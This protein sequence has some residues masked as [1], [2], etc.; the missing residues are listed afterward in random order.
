MKYRDEEYE[1]IAHP[2]IQHLNILLVSLA[3][4]NPHVHSEF[5]ISTV[6]EGEAVV[7][8]N[9]KSETTKK[10]S[11]LLLNPDQP[12]EIQAVGKDRTLILAVQLSPKFYASYSPSTQN[13]EFQELFA[14]HGEEPMSNMFF[15]SLLSLAYQYF[16]G[17][18]G[19]EFECV[20]L[21]NLILARL[22][23][24]I[25]FIRI[26]DQ[27]LAERDLRTRRLSRITTFINDHYTEKLLLSDI[28]EQEGLSMTYLSHFFRDNLNITFQQY[29]NNI[30]FEK[31]LQLMAGTNK[32]L[33]D[34]SMESG[35]SDS[36]YLNRMFMERFHCSPREYYKNM[37]DAKRD[38]SMRACIQTVFSEQE[39][40]SLLAPYIKKIESSVVHL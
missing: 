36:K 27:A 3:Y 39:C 30:R 25:P 21:M 31:A 18:T 14:Y 9:G 5:E 22:L 15:V 29:L 20:G 38:S 13:I 33:I 40:L 11:V 26:S 19:Y 35:F 28:A 23:A 2:K 8:R 17:K 1:I 12:H 7:C 4:R 16:E 37:R 6:L 34:I 32:K 24:Q 10:G